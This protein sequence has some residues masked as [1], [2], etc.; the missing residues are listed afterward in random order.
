MISPL[1]AYILNQSIQSQV[2]R[3][4]IQDLNSIMIS[5]GM[6][7]VWVSARLGHANPKVTLEYYAHLISG[8]R[9]ELV[10]FFQITPEDECEDS[11]EEK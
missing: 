10:D 5:L 9:N 7:I 4:P 3:I 6:D 1:Y 11:G 8:H 2:V